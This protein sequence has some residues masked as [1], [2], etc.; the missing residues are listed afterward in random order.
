M[1]STPSYL[2]KTHCVNVRL[3]D[4]ERQSA[5]FGLVLNYVRCV[6]DL[7][8]NQRQSSVRCGDAG[9][10]QGALVPRKK[11]RHIPWNLASR[12]LRQQS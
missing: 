3:H 9:P 10:A 5:S 12:H 4:I 1:H 2:A 11:I 8:A 7:T 6:V